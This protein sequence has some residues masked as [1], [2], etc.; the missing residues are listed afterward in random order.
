MSE[1]GHPKDAAVEMPEYGPL[2]EDEDEDVQHPGFQQRAPKRRRL[3]EWLLWGV[4]ILSCLVLLFDNI[5]LRGRQISESAFATDLTVAKHLSELIEYQFT[6][7]IQV[8]H[9]GKLYREVN[10][11]EPQYAGEPSPEIDQA[12]DDLLSVWMSIILC[13][14]LTWYAELLISDIIILLGKFHISIA[15]TLITAWTTSG[16]PFNAR[17]T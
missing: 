16:K 9:E 6:G 15:L 5:R 4:L 14:V 10:P 2:L 7:G 12:W 13:I 8:D 11:Q 1:R 3:T 17:V